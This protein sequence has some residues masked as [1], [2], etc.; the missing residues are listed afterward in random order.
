M[1][2]TLLALAAL[3]AATS[4]LPSALSP[5]TGSKHAALNTRGG[6]GFAEDDFEIQAEPD[7]AAKK[8]SADWPEVS[9]FHEEHTRELPPSHLHK[10]HV[11]IYIYIWVLLHV[12]RV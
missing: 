6:D 10:T 5:M 2:F 4:A 11:Y 12:C 8:R 9:S 3:V 1:R 7:D